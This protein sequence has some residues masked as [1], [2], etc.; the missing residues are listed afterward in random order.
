MQIA[1]KGKTLKQ[2]YKPD[3][4]CYGK[5]IV[6]IKAVKELAKEHKAQLLNY[7]KVS[8]YKLGFLVNFGA[9][10]KVEIEKIVL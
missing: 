4:T 9:V 10:P 5:I 1:Y 8:R 6:E 3:F 2:T 7:L